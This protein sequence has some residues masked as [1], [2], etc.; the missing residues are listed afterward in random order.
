[1]SFKNYGNGL[2]VISFSIWILGLWGRDL[3]LLPLAL[4]VFFILKNQGKWLEIESFFLNL[5]LKNLIYFYS[6]LFIINLALI[7][8]SYYSFGWNVWD[9]G[10]FSNML[11]NLS[12]GRLWWSYYEVHPW[13]DHFTPTISILAL[14]YK[15]YPSV[16]WI[17]NIKLIFYYF[18][19]IAFYLLIK[20]LIE[21][22]KQKI[23]FII[24]SSGW[25]LWYKPAVSSLWYEWQPSC[26]APP[27]IVLSFYFLLKSNWI[28]LFFTLIFL[29]GLKEHMGVVPCG[30]GL[31]LMLNKKIK[32][33]SI[34]FLLGVAYTTVSIYVIMPYFR[35][36]LAPWSVPR[37]EPF[38]NI[39][40]KL[41]YV[42]KLM[43]PVMFLPII[44]F[45]IGILAGPAIGVNW[46]SSNPNMQ[47]SIFHYDDIS[48]TL[49]FIS[50]ILILSNSKN[51]L[52]NLLSNKI[53]I[54]CTVFIFVLL[55]VSLGRKIVRAT[56]TKED[57]LA[58]KEI[59][60]LKQELTLSNGIA[61]Q[62]SLG[63]HFEQYNITYIGGHGE[64]CGRGLRFDGIAK[65]KK[66]LIF[67]PGAGHFKISNLEECIM[68]LE[69]SKSYKQL[70]QY[71][72]VKIFEKVD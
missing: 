58:A 25:I 42:I 72:R 20:I 64:E 2:L 61:V 49:L 10:N 63:G 31:Y 66:Y 3:Y 53:K 48:S 11:Y 57:I 68:A 36:G 46:I 44:Y 12:E 32:I 5:K 23:V 4:W 15:I 52:F 8:L 35:E 50:I 18:T 62:S 29:L 55:P 65:N 27:V 28:G 37:I 1:M 60:K 69:E 67:Y 33:G 14:F 16:L 19:V 38:E 13:A 17:L 43:I 6:F 59:E 51:L 70:S 39:G 9:S 21:E 7:P 30:F 22:K 45:R 41:A 54:L 71:N 24:I 26:L 40:H 47:T 56:P 34:L